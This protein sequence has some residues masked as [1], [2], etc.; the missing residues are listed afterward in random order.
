[1]PSPCIFVLICIFVYLGL[2]QIS[3]SS[4]VETCKNTVSVIHAKRDFSSPVR[5]CL[6]HWLRQKC[7]RQIHPKDQVRITMGLG[8]FSE[9]EYFLPPLL[10]NSVH[11]VVVFMNFWLGSWVTRSCRPSSPETT[12]PRGFP[13]S[14]VGDLSASWMVPC[15]PMSRLITKAPTK[16]NKYLTSYSKGTKPN[17]VREENNA[18]VVPGSLPEEDGIPAPQVPICKGNTKQALA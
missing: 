9:M 10:V 7:G 6:V 14:T 18:A 13:N 8:I 2:S 16:Q 11:P 4:I 15:R 17:S 1:M 3:R 12:A 5:Q